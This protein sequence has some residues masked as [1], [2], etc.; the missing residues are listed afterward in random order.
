MY[1]LQ[2]KAAQ[3]SNVLKQPSKTLLQ[4]GSKRGYF[5]LHNEHV[6]LQNTCGF[7]AACQL[8]TQAIIDSEAFRNFVMDS[9]NAFLRTAYSLA[10]VGAVAKT[11]LLRAEAITPHVKAEKVP[12]LRSRNNRK[13]AKRYNLFGTI[14][15]LLKSMV[16]SEGRVLDLD[17]RPLLLRGI[18]SL[19]ES[20]PAT[21]GEFSSY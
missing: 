17:L 16:C 12:L 5:V 6:E 11:Y 19:Q 15:N 9:N 13:I 2:I 20:L 18:K 21:S 10:T 7:D 8:I 4:N 1:F 3:T 14:G